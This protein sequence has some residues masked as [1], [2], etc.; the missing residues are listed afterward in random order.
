[1]IHSR[2][3]GSAFL[4]ATLLFYLPV[5][6]SAQGRRGGGGNVHF[7]D[8]S[9][10]PEMVDGQMKISC[11]GDPDTLIVQ[12]RDIVVFRAVGTKVNHVRW[13]GSVNQD[14][15]SLSDD[16]ELESPEFDKGSAF[17]IR[18]A[19]DIPRGRPEYKLDVMCGDH[20]DG[21]PMIIVDP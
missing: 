10:Q 6:T 19:N 9:L 14:K 1:M 16:S 15:R 3:M 17:A 5:D 4:L 11:L 8:L 13:G 2:L 20:P 21:P 12:R 7:M 18:I